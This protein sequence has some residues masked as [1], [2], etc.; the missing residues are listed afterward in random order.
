MKME[1]EITVEVDTDFNSLDKLLKEHGFE[2]KKECDLNDIYMIRKEDKTGD[3]LTM[4]SKCILLRH[5]F[6][7][8]FDK[9]RLSYKYKE[10]NDHME[11]IKDGKIEV[12]IDDI[13]KAKQLLEVFNFEELLRIYDHM[14]IYVSDKDEF[15]VQ[16]V[17]NKHIYI[18]IENKCNIVNRTYQSQDE[19]KQVFI[20]NN[21]PIKENN[22]FVRKALIELEEN[23][24]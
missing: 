9:K 13:D 5:S 17:N 21:I 4:L 2:V 16:V 3:Y 1:N 11:L 10:Y 6:N 22:Y 8:D 23:K 15:A 20:D 24:K 19:M 18:E 12:I 14:Y 7:K